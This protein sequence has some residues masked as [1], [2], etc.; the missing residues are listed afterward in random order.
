MLVFVS[1]KDEIEVDIFWR[2]P[3]S[4]R[5]EEASDYHNDS[6]NEK[7]DYQEYNKEQSVV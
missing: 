4:F 6:S 1:V 2:Y 5:V 7:E 3:D